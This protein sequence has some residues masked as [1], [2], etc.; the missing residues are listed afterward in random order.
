MA[1]GA[2]SHSRTAISFFGTSKVHFSFNTLQSNTVSNV[3]LSHM[4]SHTGELPF[5]CQFCAKK[6]VTK[7]NLNAHCKKYHKGRKAT[8]ARAL[9]T[10]SSGQELS[11]QEISP[12]R[13]AE[14]CK[15]TRS[16]SM[17]TRS[18]KKD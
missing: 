6:F 15:E 12:T 13:N 17:A 4:R 11:S 10:D 8:S 7:S 14:R 3:L 16:H 5:T 2:Q 18:M 9:E 1:A